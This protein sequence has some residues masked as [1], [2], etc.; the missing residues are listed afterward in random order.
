[1]KNQIVENNQPDS[2]TSTNNEGL[3][4]N[5]IVTAIIVVLPFV[6]TVIGIGFLFSSGISSLE[7]G[8]LVTM[9]LLTM[10]GS[11][12][13]F[14]RYF[15]HNSFKTTTPIQAILAILGLMSAQGGLLYWVVGHPHHHKYSD[16]TGD[17]HS[18]HLS[19]KGIINQLRG[20]Y[21]AHIGWV[22]DIANTDEDSVIQFKKLLK[23]PLILRINQLQLVWIL[24]G[25]VLPG[26]IEGIVTWSWMG[27]FKGFIWGG[28]VRLFLVQQFIGSVNSICHIYGDRHF[29]TKDFSTNNIWL[30]I[31]TL[32]QSWHHNHHAFPNSAIFGLEWWQ[33]D[34]GKWLIW[35]LEKTGLVWDVK[36]PTENMIVA[37]KLQS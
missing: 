31:P 29:K 2:P 10:L 12:V 28:L 19:G 27:A 5:T 33:I 25:L 17:L 23:D 18:P 37:R 24:L 4:I 6:G 16:V 34:L 8:L 22:F 13:G 30:A 3:S 36:R 35:L 11:D 9:Y 14:H 21:H 7:I 1:M 15:A 32:G 20:F 26:V